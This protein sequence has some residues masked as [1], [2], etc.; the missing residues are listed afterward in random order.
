V[1]PTGKEILRRLNAE[2]DAGLR[3]SVSVQF[4][5][6]QPRC[7]RSRRVRRHALRHAGDD[8]CEGRVRVGKSALTKQFIENLKHDDPR[9]VTFAGRCYE[10]ESVPY[11]A[12]DGVIDSMSRFLASIDAAPLLPRQRGLI[13][14]VFR[15]CAASARSPRRRST[16]SRGSTR[17]DHPRALVFGSARL[18]TKIAAAVPVV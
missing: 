13:G 9:V 2:E 1:R 18:F 14:Q 10:R 12:I 8:A 4:I 7:S 16:A 3:T 17:K 11:K 6:R 15:S 5:G